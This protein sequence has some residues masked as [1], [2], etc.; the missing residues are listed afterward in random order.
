MIGAGIHAAGPGA[1]ASR[2]RI[3]FVHTAIAV[4]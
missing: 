3:S 1:P 2:D 4:T